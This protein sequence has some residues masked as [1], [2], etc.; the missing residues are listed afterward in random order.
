MKVANCSAVVLILTL[1][2]FVY[3]GSSQDMNTFYFIGQY[4]SLLELLVYTAV[5]GWTLHKLQKDTKE[6]KKLMP[7]Q[8]LFALHRTLLIGYI[9]FRAVNYGVVWVILNTEPGFTYYIAFGL[10]NITFIVSN[11]FESTIFYLV[12]S[13]MLP[14]TEAQK[15]KT[16]NVEKF[17]LFGCFIDADELERALFSQH[18]DL[19]EL[20]KG[21]IRQ[22]I[23]DLIA[24][25]RPS[26]NTNAIVGGMIDAIE[27]YNMQD[28]AYWGYVKMRVEKAKSY[29]N[30]NPHDEPD[31]A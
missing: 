20:Q 16:Q 3:I 15:K 21:F 6:S 9:I 7:N 27:S 2:I 11:L 4:G 17:F 31:P 5:W 18:P 13:L 29:D 1:A 19:P 30:Y 10:A 26:K 28:T 14:I 8:K 23:K 12:V 24:R 22:D 25:V